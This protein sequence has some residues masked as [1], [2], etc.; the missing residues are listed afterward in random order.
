MS[1]TRPATIAAYIAAA[2]SAGQ[3]H[4]RRLH[5]ILKQAAPEAQEAMKWNTPFFI[6]PRFLFAFTAHKAHIGFAPAKAAWEQ[7]AGELAQYKTTKGTLQLPYQ[8]PL[9]ED[10]IRRIA[11]CCVASVAAREDDG[12]W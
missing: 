1:T 2:P 4:L 11:L 3:P 5:A 6:E 9:P 10:L 12:F 7:F 8:A